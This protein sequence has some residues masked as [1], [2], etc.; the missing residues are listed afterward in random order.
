MVHTFGIKNCDTM[1]KARRWL[2]E[3]GVDYTFHD[4]KA[5]AID[6]KR[7]KAW[8]VSVGWERLLNRRGLTWRALKDDQKSDMDADRAIALMVESPTLIKRPV[9]EIG[10]HIEVG[11]SPACYAALL[12]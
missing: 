12:S 4:F 2:D 5:E 10:G 6:S 9:L 8:C 3:S 11:F 7:L 1:K